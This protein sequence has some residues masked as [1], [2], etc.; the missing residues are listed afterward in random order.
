MH[1]VIVDGLAV[2]TGT[3][4]YQEAFSLTCLTTRRQEGV[5]ICLS[6]WNPNHGIQLLMFWEYLSWKGLGIQQGKLWAGGPWLLWWCSLHHGRMAVVKQHWNFKLASHIFW[7]QIATL[8]GYLV[9]HKLNLCP[10]T[11][12]NAPQHQRTPTNTSVWGAH[13]AVTAIHLHVSDRVWVGDTHCGWTSQTCASWMGP[14]TSTQSISNLPPIYPIIFNHDVFN[15]RC[16]ASRLE[17]TA[18]LRGV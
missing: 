7:L 6:R 1:I 16:M 2:S 9:H 18:I 17:K 15:N 8:E 3:K 12:E 14:D 13:I 10:K 11:L 4:W 5:S